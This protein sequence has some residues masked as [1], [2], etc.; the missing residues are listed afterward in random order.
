MNYYED[1]G[2]AWEFRHHMPDPLLL[3]E[4]ADKFNME[5]YVSIFEQINP[6]TLIW[7]LIVV[8]L[9]YW[10]FNDIKEFLKAITDKITELTSVS[11]NRADFNN[12]T[13]KFR[14][15]VQEVQE[16]ASTKSKKSNNAETKKQTNDMLWG[17]FL[18]TLDKKVKS[19][20]DALQK[21][22]NMVFLT[23]FI[24]M[25]N[26][27]MELYTSAIPKEKQSPFKR[28]S[29]AIFNEL[30]EAKIIILDTRIDSFMKVFN[31]VFNL[32]DLIMKDEKP[33]KV[34]DN[35]RSYLRGL[36]ITKYK[37]DEAIKNQKTKKPKNA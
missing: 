15:D 4:W 23:L 18:D 5:N 32:Q 6:N 20:E 29:F 24:E 27:L 13:Q 30:I 21:D 2:W 19:Y 22:P 36:L 25:D 28:S 16:A 26:L 34:I 10:F 1:N 8:L 14:E 37:I 33:L 3:V 31:G 9:V 11:R 7:Q 12:K 17:K 35:A